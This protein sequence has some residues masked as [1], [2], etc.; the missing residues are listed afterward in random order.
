MRNT[1][2]LYLVVLIFVLVGQVSGQEALG[3]E[4]KGLHAV[5]AVA[6]V[7]LPFDGG[8]SEL[9]TSAPLAGIG[10]TFNFGVDITPSGFLSGSLGIKNDDNPNWN[11]KAIVGVIGWKGA[12]AGLSWK[13]AEE[14]IG[15][16]GLKKSTLA[17]VLGFN[18]K[19]L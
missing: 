12:I 2:L 13:F 16:Q 17:F 15:V 3:K 14:G 6:P 8:E 5:F 11:L 19:K 7:S 9:L 10:Y 18:F 1:S 4:N